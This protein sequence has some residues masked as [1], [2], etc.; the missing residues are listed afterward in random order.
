MARNTPQCVE[1]ILAYHVQIKI[2]MRINRS[3]EY[4]KC[5]QMDRILAENRGLSCTVNDNG[6]TMCRD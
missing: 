6:F 1:L 4:K 2:R 3:F 5:D